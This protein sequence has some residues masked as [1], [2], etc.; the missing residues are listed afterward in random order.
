MEQSIAKAA[1][2]TGTAQKQTERAAHGDAHGDARAQLAVAL[3][4]D[5]LRIA[6]LRAGTQTTA[7]F[8][9][10]YRML[11]ALGDSGLTLLERTFALLRVMRAENQTIQLIL[12]EHFVELCRNAEQRSVG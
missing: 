6:T 7:Y 5:P 11:P 3:L 2:L 1:S 8:F 9:P 12:E 10:T 4:L